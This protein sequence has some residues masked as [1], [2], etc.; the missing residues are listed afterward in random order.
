MIPSGDVAALTADPAD[1]ARCR[2]LWCAVLNMALADAASM[3][4]KKGALLA[5][6][7][8]AA[9]VGGNDFVEVCDLAGVGPGPMREKITQALAACPEQ[10]LVKRL[11]KFCAETDTA[12]QAVVAFARDSAPWVGTWLGLLE[13][14]TARTQSRGERWP[15]KDIGLAQRMRHAWKAIRPVCIRVSGTESPRTVRITIEPE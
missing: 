9:W 11:P 12:V 6:R 8:V 13:A 1:T 15:K 5:K 7:Q 10:P 3:P 4:N 14:I 2:A